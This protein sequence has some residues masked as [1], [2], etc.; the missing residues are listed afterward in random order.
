M[1]HWTGGLDVLGKVEMLT[2]RDVKK[3]VDNMLE[4]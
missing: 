1:P 4:K 3:F 2:Y